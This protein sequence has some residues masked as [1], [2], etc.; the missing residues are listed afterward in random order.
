MEISESFSIIPSLNFYAMG[1]KLTITNTFIIYI[2]Y[3]ANER[4]Q[5]GRN[6]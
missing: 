3:N 5:G 6:R 4:G 1:L 2:I